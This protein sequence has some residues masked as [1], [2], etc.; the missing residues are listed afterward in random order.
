M[1]THIFLSAN[2]VYEF[3]ISS[4]LNMQNVRSSTIL[5]IAIAYSFIC[6]NRLS[7]K[8]TRVIKQE[9]YHMYNR[10]ACPPQFY[11]D[12]WMFNDQNGQNGRFA[13]SFKIGATPHYHPVDV[14]DMRRI[15][16]KTPGSV[17]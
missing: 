3:F 6:A 1:V 7:T 11:C 8:H 13:T 17:E 10:R 16:S 2:F 15:M 4:S 14:F 12:I 9:D 5:D